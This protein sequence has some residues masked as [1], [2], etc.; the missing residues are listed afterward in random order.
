MTIKHR[1]EPNYWM[2]Y[3]SACKGVLRLPP[4]LVADILSWTIS[5]KLN[6]SPYDYLVVLKN[7]EDEIEYWEVI[8]DDGVYDIRIVN[9]FT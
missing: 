4:T 2:T 6:C 5:C 9:V 1:V 7:Q 8:N 3:S